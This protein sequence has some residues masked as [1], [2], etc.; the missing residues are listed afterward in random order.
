MCELFLLLQVMLF[1]FSFTHVLLELIFCFSVLLFL[2]S[3]CIYFEKFRFI[4][5]GNLLKLQLLVLN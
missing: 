5:I 3:Y 4:H 2:F 1:F